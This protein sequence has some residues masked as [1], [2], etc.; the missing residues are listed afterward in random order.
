MNDEMKMILSAADLAALQQAHSEVVE[1][2][3][4][5]DNLPV[6]VLG[7]GVGVKWRNNQPTGIPALIVLVDQK[8]AKSKLSRADLLPP[9]LKGMNMDVIPVGRLAAKAGSLRLP[10]EAS[11]LTHHIRPVQ[12]GYSVGH[13][14]ITA[15]TIA[16]CV[17]DLLPQGIGIPKKYYI[18]SNNHVL[19]AQNNARYGDPIIQ[20]GPVDGGCCPFDTI[21]TLSRFI[22][23]DFEPL[24]PRYLHD[25]IVDA[26]IAQSQLHN[27]DRA[28]SWIGYVG[29]WLPQ[30]KVTVGMNVQKTGRTTGFTRGRIL[31]TNVTV[32]ISY[33]GG[34]TARFKDQIMSTA[35]TAGGDSGALLITLID[36]IPFAV[37]LH[38]ASS[39]SMSIAN[40]IENVRTLLRVEIAENSRYQK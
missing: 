5:P 26:A 18:L 9:I 4:Y 36:N 11:S 37:G 29:G 28:I 30:E 1:E 13:I 31:A 7:L 16:T 14:D 40:Q 22:P 33:A 6:N 24:I 25:N 32:D 39:P 2:F 17:Y 38:F 3:L 35:M 8:V 10:N 20:P 15:G 12:G 21:A 27:L 34:K 23:I 19:A